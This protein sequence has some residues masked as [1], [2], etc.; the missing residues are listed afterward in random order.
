MDLQYHA[1]D[2]DPN[3][4]PCPNIDNIDQKTKVLFLRL[5]K[6]NNQ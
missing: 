4:D 5:Y 6:N 3:K 1:N 2:V